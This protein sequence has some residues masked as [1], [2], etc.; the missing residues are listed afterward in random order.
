[1]LFQNRFFCYVPIILAFFALAGCSN[2]GIK[3]QLTVDKHI[4]AALAEAAVA[5]P[6]PI[7]DVPPEVAQALMPVPALSALKQPAT[8]P[9]ERFDLSVMQAPATEFFIGLVKGTRYNVVIDPNMSGE[10]SLDMNN[11]TLQEVLDAVRE[12]YG[13]EYRRIGN[14]YMLSMP[15]LQTRTFTVDY[16]NMQRT[17]KSTT[18]VA[19][20]GLAEGGT[21]VMLDTESKDRFWVNLKNTIIALLGIDVTT[22]RQG[23]KQG[24]SSTQDELIAVVDASGRAIGLNPQS[25]TVVVRGFPADLRLVETLLGQAKDSIVRQV[26]LE[27]KV[28]EVELNDGY[29]SGINWATLMNAGSWSLGLAQVGGGTVLGSAA[30][31]EIA[32][33]SVPLAPGQKFDSSGSITSSAF[34][35]VF[36]ASLTKG[37]QFSSFIELLK[38]QG[39]VHVLSSPRISTMNNQKAV[40]KVGGDE[41]FVTNV[42][43][44][45]QSTVEGITTRSRP[46]LELLPFFSGIALDVTP[47]I[48][49]DDNVILHVHPTISEVKQASKVV[50]LGADGTWTLPTAASSVRES[51]SIVRARSGQVIVIGGLMKERSIG[52]D[53]STPGLGDL[54]G[55]GGL[56]HHELQA[57]ARSE[58][59]ILIKPTV[60]KNGQAWS[61]VAQAA[62]DRIQQM[63]GAREK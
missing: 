29:Q 50:D 61:A 33:N 5:A 59:V 16:I 19:S 51:D 7:A 32:G 34:G 42:T 36:A 54:P 28:I 23:Q 31:S 14:T 18:Q 24:Q 63:R 9:E 37:D 48:D 53:A 45:G 62:R 6:Q 55:I 39:N 3:E 17:G 13:Y 1:M 20:S 60:V 26:I 57:Q 10:I 41:Y 30:L 56:F 47:Q 49:A 44:G 46:A 25:G 58:L 8:T 52:K 11:V 21:G 27:A 2:M 4:D 15:Q 43:G 38:R 22:H 12:I 40:I 35:G